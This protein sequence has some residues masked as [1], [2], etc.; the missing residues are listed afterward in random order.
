M[1]HLNFRQL[2]AFHAVAEYGSI[3]A[4]ARQLH[5]SQPAVSRLIAELEEH[6]GFTL[7]QRFANGSVPTQEGLEL[8][9]DVA[10]LLAMSERVSE[11][12]RSIHENRRKRLLVGCP[13]SIAARCMPKIIEAAMRREASFSVAISV[14][15]SLS[16]IDMVKRGFLDVALAVVPEGRADVRHETLI[17][18]DAV[19]LLP[20]G[21]ALATERVLTPKTLGRYPIVT[22]P[23]LG[24]FRADLDSSFEAC[25]LQL[26]P[27]VEAYSSCFPGLV[28]AGAGIALG[29]PLGLLG[30]SAHGLVIRPYEPAVTLSLSLVFPDQIALDVFEHF[31]AASRTVLR[32]ELARLI[33]KGRRASR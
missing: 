32:E 29:D 30:D 15:R 17:S 20:V 25:G 21:H 19:C 5:I 26:V 31:A 10:R 33:K 11:D 12:A 23:R 22:N 9:T 8:H 3:S 13:N 1:R 7:F 16:L 27:S 28:E 6:V 2:E 24:K 14:E 4:A 18:V